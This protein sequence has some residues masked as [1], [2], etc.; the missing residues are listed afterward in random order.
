[1]K[2]PSL[3]LGLIAVAVGAAA[4]ACYPLVFSHGSNCTIQAACVSN[5]KQTGLALLS[6]AA[7]DDD[8]LPV[9]NQWATNTMQ[10]SKS[11]DVYRCP[12]AK[13][14]KEF[15]HAFF[16]PLGG[17]NVSSFNFPAAQV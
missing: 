16:L 5:L 2:F 11:E 4:V 7:D 12:L 17:K 3:K 10:Y 6:Y 8:R 9:A 13:Y 1:M 15:G 14:P